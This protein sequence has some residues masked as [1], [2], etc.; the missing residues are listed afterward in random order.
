MA[1]S[2]SHSICI[3][4]THF[5][6][7]LE[8]PSSSLSLGLAG[9]WS[10]CKSASIPCNWI[11]TRYTTWDGPFGTS[12]I[13][14]FS[15]FTIFSMYWYYPYICLSQRALKPALNIEELVPH[16]REVSHKVPTCKFNCVLQCIAVDD[17]KGDHQITA[18]VNCLTQ[19]T[20]WAS[21]ALIY[22]HA[23]T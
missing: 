1:L 21:T 10:T 17:S 13:Y 14:T 9:G 22:P 6:T 7:G 11:G 3:S 16:H 4:I 23:L 2:T 8:A 18:W 15:T 20:R 19:V 5:A 12:S